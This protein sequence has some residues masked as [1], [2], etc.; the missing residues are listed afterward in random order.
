ME[1]NLILIDIETTGLDPKNNLILEVAACNIKMTSEDL[2]YDK[3][4]HFY[5][6]NDIVNITKS[7]NEYT[8]K[9]HRDNNLLY[10]IFENERNNNFSNTFDLNDTNCPLYSLIEENKNYYLCG[11]SVHFDK[12]FLKYH[13]PN[14]ENKFSH[15]I[16]DLTS[17]LIMKYTF[18]P[19]E[20]KSSSHRALDDVLKSLDI[21]KK[22][23]ID[24][25]HLEDLK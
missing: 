11:N 20:K 10:E 8:L 7:L 14:F 6:K 13:M 21:L 2:I 22:M 23:Y 12:S 9:M 5:V 19:Y 4:I 15:R 25:R 24:I 16:L 18:S 3:P 1:T 17:Y